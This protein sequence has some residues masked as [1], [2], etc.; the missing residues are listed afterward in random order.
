MNPR[1]GLGG[2]DFIARKERRVKQ[3]KGGGGG[4][5]LEMGSGHIITRFF[6]GFFMMQHREKNLCVCLSFVNKLNIKQLLK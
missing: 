4:G 2:L 3:N 5:G 1:R 6:W